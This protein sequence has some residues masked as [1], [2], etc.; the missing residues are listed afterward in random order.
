M[1]NRI[2]GLDRCL[3]EIEALV[4]E[5]R[6]VDRPEHLPDLGL[7][8]VDWPQKGQFCCDFWRSS[9]TL[10]AAF[11]FRKLASFFEKSNGIDLVHSC[12]IP[13]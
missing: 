12:N 2:A 9:Q 10:F 3:R 5:A 7:W 11:V 4:A 13:G 1:G 8:T 6:A